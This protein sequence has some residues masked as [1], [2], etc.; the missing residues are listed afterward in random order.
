MAF[1]IHG[2]GIIYFTTQGAMMQ[3]SEQAGAEIKV[4]R[5]MVSAGMEELREH[6]FLTDPEYIIESVYRAMAYVARNSASETI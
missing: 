1:L 5:D 6:R 2:L 3:N 4:T